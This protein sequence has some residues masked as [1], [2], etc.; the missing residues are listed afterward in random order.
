MQKKQSVLG[1]KEASAVKAA[2][3]DLLRGGI[4]FEVCTAEEAKIAEEAGALAVVTRP[5]CNSAFEQIEKIQEAVTI[6]VIA[7]CRSGHSVEAAMLEALFI[8]FIDESLF[9]DSGLT[10]HKTD[11]QTPFISPIT[12]LKSALQKIAEGATILRNGEG[13]ATLSESMKMLNGLK[14]GFAELSLLLPEEIAHW[15][16]NGGHSYEVV[17]RCRELGSLPIPL[18]VASEVRDLSDV[19]LLMQMGADGLILP[20]TFMEKEDPLAFAKS[21]V[22]GATHYS[23]PD[24]LLKYL[25]GHET[26]PKHHHH[27][28]KREE[29]A[30][31]DLNDQL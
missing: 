29:I 28:L 23:E 7:Y 17:S 18:L 16:A 11:F 13:F 5:E 3:A 26:T 10:I 14:T 21:L 12:D 1:L 8:D 22:F 31:Q 9:A 4:L 27:L 24:Q 19:A 6:P 20:N 15:C 2:L 25:L 30:V